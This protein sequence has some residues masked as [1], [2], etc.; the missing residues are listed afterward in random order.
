[1]SLSKESFHD[2]EIIGPAEAAVI[3]STASFRVRRRRDRLPALMHRFRPAGAL[4]DNAP[5]LQDERLLDFG[6]PFITGF[7]GFVQAAG[8]AYLLEPLPMCTFLTTIWRSLLWE[9]PV[10]APSFLENAAMQIGSALTC[11]ALAGGSHGA[12]A[13]RN[14]VMTR[15]GVCGV[16]AARLSC[17]NGDLVLRQGGC[18]EGDDD[19]NCLGL[20][21]E[22]M[23]TIANQMEVAAKRPVLLPRHYAHLAEL[24]GKYKY[25]KAYPALDHRP[26]MK[27]RQQ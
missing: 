23:L 26:S 15:H 5:L 25:H 19:L 17:T 12:I 14:L 24:A 10:S 8:S 18:S 2:Y 20:T 9:S 11:L 7:T 21:I 22:Q 3:G 13:P 16:L 6:R 27:G 4:I 1:V